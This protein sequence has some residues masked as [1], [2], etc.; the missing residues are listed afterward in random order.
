M[1]NNNNN[2]VRIDPATGQRIINFS[3]GPGLMPVSVLAEA[4][5]SMASFSQG[6]GLMELSHRGKAF[7]AVLAETEADFRQLL[8]IPDGYSVLFMQGGAT[9]QFSTVALNLVGADADAKCDY[10]VTGAWSA[11]AAEEAERLLGKERV[12]V[13]VSTKKSKHNGDIPALDQWKFSQKQAYVFYCDNETVHGVE[14]GNKFPFDAIPSNVPLICD[15]SSNILSGPIDVSKY[16]LIFAGAQKNMGPAGVTVV[17][18][19]D[20]L[21]SPSRKCTTQP[22][23]QLLDYNTYSTSQSMYNTPPTFPIYMCGLVFKWLKTEIGGLDQMSAINTAKSSA[24]YNAIDGSNGFYV[25]PVNKAYRSRMNVCFLVNPK[26]PDAAALEKRFL[27]EAEAK[28][29]VQLAGHRSVGGVRAS[30][31]NAMTLE[32]VEILVAFMKEFQARV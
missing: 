10:I 6:H 12:N 5:Q 30:L 19:R 7:E 28:G 32:N 31:Y 2:N 13:V 1:T 22:I 11:K 20:D 27:A 16:G 3:A 15:M 24:L 14:F 23:P 25:C 8:A 4:G 29:M 18:I 9:L 26:S 17:I 21:L